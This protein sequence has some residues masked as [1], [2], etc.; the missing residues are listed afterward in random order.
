MSIVTGLPTSKLEAEVDKL[1]YKYDSTS[2]FVYP[3]SLGVK[4]FEVSLFP[5]QLFAKVVSVGTLR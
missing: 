5:H 1:R 2:A 3:K 4:S